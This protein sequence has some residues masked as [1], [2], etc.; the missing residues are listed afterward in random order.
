[1]T[2][3]WMNLLSFWVGFMM[4]F[5]LFAMLQASREEDKRPLPRSDEYRFP[6]GH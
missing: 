2:D 6:I 1:M 4:G 5:G 3:I